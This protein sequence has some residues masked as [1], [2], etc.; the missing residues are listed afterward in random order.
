MTL[1]NA[2]ITLDEFKNYLFPAGN[3][4]SVEDPQMEAAITAACRSIDTYCARR[5]FVDTN[6]SARYY[7]ADEPYC[8]DVDDF[9]TTTGL[10]VKTDSYDNGTYD[11]AWTINTDFTV[12]PVNREKDGLT[13]LPYNEI[14]GLQTRYFPQGGVREHRVEVTAKWGWA[15]VPDSVKQASFIKAARIYRRAKTP[16]GFAA[17]ESFGAIRVSTREDPDVCMLLGPFRKVGGA[18]LVVA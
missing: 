9:S 2:Y 3:G 16:D 18:G 1:T 14:V 13:G 10:T 4:G 8:L 11:Q 15:A 17:G 12:A 6:T 5:F 7:H